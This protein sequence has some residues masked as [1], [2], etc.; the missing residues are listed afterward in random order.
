MNPRLENATVVRAIRPRR[1]ACVELRT[2]QQQRAAVQSGPIAVSLVLAVAGLRLCQV[3]SASENKHRLLAARFPV[4]V[5]QQR[6]Q[7]FIHWFGSHH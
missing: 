3:Y 6:Q 2:G 7:G 4:A 1:G 5:V